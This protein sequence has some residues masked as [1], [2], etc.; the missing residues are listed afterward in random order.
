MR[1]A[2]NLI[3]AMVAYLNDV[4]RLSPSN[5]LLL[6]TTMAPGVWL[7]IGDIQPQKNQV[8]DSLRDLQN[9]STPQK[10]LK[11]Q[12]LMS[13]DGSLRGMQDFRES[14][15]A[16]PP[17]FKDL[18]SPSTSGSGL[19]HCTLSP[20]PNR[21]PGEQDLKVFDDIDVCAPN[22]IGELCVKIGG[23]EWGNPGQWL[24]ILRI[25]ES[26]S[27]NLV[28]QTF[29]EK[30]AVSIREAKVATSSSTFVSDLAYVNSYFGNLPGVIVSLKARNLPLIESVKIMHTIQEGVKQTTGPVASNNGSSLNVPSISKELASGDKFTAPLSASKKDLTSLKNI[31]LVV[32]AVSRATEAGLHNLIYKKCGQNE[33]LVLFKNEYLSAGE[34]SGASIALEIDHGMGPS[35]VGVSRKNKRKIPSINLSVEEDS[36][37]LGRAIKSKTRETVEP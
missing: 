26:P 16:L 14:L 28:I 31:S 6:P 35:N 24:R 18:R 36:S 21:H 10:A 22:M 20:R 37:K 19:T 8:I 25:S 11:F 34:S 3:E 4:I 7:S 32:V 23:G 29:D 27:Q 1:L 12:D 30:D 33:N 13:P 5:E 2:D 17:V 15:D 9:Y